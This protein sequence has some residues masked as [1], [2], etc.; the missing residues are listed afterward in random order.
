MNTL[1]TALATPYKNGKIDTFSYE[2][3]VHYQLFNGVDALLAIGTTGEAQLLRGG[4]KHQLIKITKRLAENTPVWVGI[5]GRSTIDSVREA[6]IAEDNGADGILVAPPAFVK[7]TP[8]GFVQHIKEILKYVS[9]PVMLY[10]APS[11]C[12]YI[13]DKD[14]VC[15]LS[16]KVRYIKDAG[17][18]LDYTAA[19]S[20]KLNVLCGNDLLLPEMLKNGANGVISVVSNVAP[21][22]TRRILDGV[23]NESEYEQFVRLSK[24]SM[25]EVSPI[26]I[27]YMLYKQDIFESYNM[28]LPLTRANAD[29]QQQINEM[30]DTK[31]LG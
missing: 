16:E 27:K 23:A 18:D 8:Q 5:C 4:E 15:E 28:R 11:R 30:W 26:A 12:N 19:L 31:P 9:V 29:T 24:L 14:A 22:L 13:L 25:L 3:L 6:V 10:N 7:C 21:K 2:K 17:K 20:K 1:I